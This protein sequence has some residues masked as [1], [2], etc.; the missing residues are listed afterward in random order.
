MSPEWLRAVS[1]TGYG[2]TLSVAVGVPIPIL[3]EEMMTFVSVSDAELKAPLVDYSLYYPTGE[4]EAKLGEV[5]YAQLKSG[6]IELL[7]K[8]IPTGCFSSYAKAREVAELLKH[9]IT[10][11]EFLLTQSTSPLPGPNAG[12]EGLA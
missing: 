6:T 1:F 12:K 9:Q 3:D 10:K 8:K 2:V 11:G 4:G 5:T 7:G